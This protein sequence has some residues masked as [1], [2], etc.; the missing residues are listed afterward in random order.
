MR[1]EESLSRET[2]ARPFGRKGMAVTMP[3]A[4]RSSLVDDIKLFALTFA[5][6]FLFVSL[7]LA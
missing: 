7:Y 1:I 5:C 2:H 3:A 4:P 6:G